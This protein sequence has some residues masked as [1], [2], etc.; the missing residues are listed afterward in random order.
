MAVFRLTL[1]SLLVFCASAVKYTVYPKGER[2]SSPPCLSLEQYLTNASHY[3]TDNSFFLFLPGSHY[4][5]STLN[6]ENLENVTLAGTMGIT[7]LWMSN[8]FT[9]NNSLGFTVDGLDITYEGKVTKF[10]FKISNSNE[11]VLSNTQFNNLSDINLESSNGYISN[12]SF[13]LSEIDISNST[14]VFYDA[15]FSGN[16]AFGIECGLSNVTFIHSLIMSGLRF[17]LIASF[18]TV[19]I[20]G[21]A[22]FE[23]NFRAIHLFKSQLIV[24]GLLLC[25]NNAGDH[26]VGLYTAEK[27]SL[28][29]R[30]PVMVSF[31]NNTAKTIGAA[32]H[33]EDSDITYLKLCKNDVDTDY[34]C[35]FEIESESSQFDDVHFEFINNTAGDSGSAVYGGILKQCRV[36]V[37]KVLQ[38]I[39]GYSL[40]QQIST[41]SQDETISSKPLKV[42]LCSFPKC[43]TSIFQRIIP[44]RSFD[45]AVTA[46][47]E[48]NSTTATVGV[49]TF[50]DGVISAGLK[51]VLKSNALIMPGCSNLTFQVFSDLSDRSVRFVVFP[52][53]CTYGDIVV[54]LIVSNCP[55][56][57]MLD[58]NICVCEKTLQSL[59]DID[60][61]VQNGLIENGGKYWISPNYHNHTYSGVKWCRYCPRGYCSSSSS[62]HPIQIDLS[63]PN[64]S[65]S[66]CAMN[67]C[68]TLCGACATGYSLTLNTLE[69]K[70]CSNKT[71]SLIVLFAVAGM[72]LIALL[73]FLQMTVASG[74]LNGL[75]LYANIVN[76]H[77]DVFFPREADS[78]D[79]KPLEVFISWLNLDFGI[80][81]CFYDGLNAYQYYWLQYAF[82]LYLWILTGIII[83]GSNYSYKMRRLLGSNPVAVLATVI[84][85]SYNKCLQA[86]VEALAFANLETS[87][88]QYTKVWLYDGNLAYIKDWQHI[89]L[90]AGAIS[91]IA[92]FV[93]PYALLLSFGHSLQAFSNRKWFHW[94]NKFTPLLDAHYAPFNKNGRYWPGLM[95]GL[96]IVLFL[97]YMISNDNLMVIVCTIFT[98]TIALQWKIYKNFYLMVF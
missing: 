18:S 38:N 17:A 62:G 10:P 7:Y 59:P 4:T 85:M 30:G 94:F 39:K 47:G 81:L 49:N 50:Y 91:V 76:V 60:C 88:G 92:F 3:F 20:D 1:L 11:L 26:G 25:K 55:N 45:M 65:N 79:V 46:L 96:R 64:G 84:L 2:C 87:E 21:N 89:I 48:V 53:E 5:N 31:L 68:G 77:R 34:A 78:S 63:S 73:L 6:L 83:V 19:T 75:I 9:C 98:A 56:G 8:V 43:P 61:N 42:C 40:L 29:L 82:P 23:Y 70:D 37:N 22:T 54:H 27:S 12:C 69:C 51:V 67:R 71:V 66:Q 14:V 16:V 36:K 74:T 58:T 28:V 44:G 41:F 13:S 97:S 95:L 35:F 32:V 72:G 80:P 93:L 57:F 90:A 86:S 15:F 52:Y 33:I 24:S